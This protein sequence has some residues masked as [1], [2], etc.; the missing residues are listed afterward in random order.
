MYINAR[1]HCYTPRRSLRSR[2]SNFLVTPQTTTVTYG[3]RSFAAIA[4]KLWISYRLPLDKVTLSLHRDIYLWNA[5][6]RMHS[7][8]HYKCSLF[9]QKLRAYRTG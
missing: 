5:F 3:D 2:D 1:L 4:P 8:G 6:L 7:I 9:D